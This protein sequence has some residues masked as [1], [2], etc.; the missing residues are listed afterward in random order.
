MSSNLF[1]S[2]VEWVKKFNHL[3]IIIIH[4]LFNFLVNVL[5]L[6]FTVFPAFISK[7]YE[8]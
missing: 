6:S 3:F 7:V 2:H 5:M 1:G 4:D 8:S